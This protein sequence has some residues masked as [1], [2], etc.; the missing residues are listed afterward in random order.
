MKETLHSR[1]D[2]WLAIVYFILLLILVG[3][4]GPLIYL[5]PAW[6][7]FAGYVS[8]CIFVSTI[9]VIFDHTHWG[10]GTGK[11]KP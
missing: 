3:S 10:S 4:L 6:M 8:I 9:E 1:N 2:D 11:D 7:V 5:M